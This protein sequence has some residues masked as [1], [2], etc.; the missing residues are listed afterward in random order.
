MDA[1]K[2]SS[3]IIT[4]SEEDKTIRKGPWSCDEDSKLV[5]YIA[6]HGEGGW[7]AL[8]RNAGLR[9]TGKSCRLRWLNYL[10]PNV[11]RGNI[12]PQEQL[13]IIEL[14]LSY[15]NRWT[16]IAKRLPGRTDNEIKNYWRTTIKK[17][18]TQLKCDVNSKEF[19]DI[20]CCIWLPSIIEK[21]NSE[22]QS[23][24]NCQKLMT[25][26]E[27]H[28]TGFGMVEMNCRANMLGFSSE[29]MD[30]LSPMYSPFS[31]DFE[32]IDDIQASMHGGDD[33]WLG[34]EDSFTTLLDEDDLWHAQQQQSPTRRAG[35][36]LLGFIIVDQHWA[37]N[38]NNTLFD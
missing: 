33:Y 16:E 24:S 37:H 14:H 11:R 35:S 32:G 29:P 27:V 13:R 2:V 36:L 3:N 34:Y 28:Q 9:R 21:A 5:N 38:I 23:N 7:E 31:H 17:Q 19:L 6:I 4:Q 22:T 8:A 15:G 1:K 10:N 25:D 30:N 18:A 12:T 26:S 20:M